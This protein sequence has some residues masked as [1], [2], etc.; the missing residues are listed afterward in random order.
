[1]SQSINHNPF[2]LTVFEH[3]D[4]RCREWLCNLMFWSI[5]KPVPHWSRNERISVHS[6]EFYSLRYAALF[7]TMTL[8]T[9]HLQARNK[10]PNRSSPCWNGVCNNRVVN[11]IRP[12]FHQEHRLVRSEQKLKIYEMIFLLT[13]GGLMV[14]TEEEQTAT[15]LL[16]NE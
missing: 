5:Y 1:M 8:V 10:E 4:N 9:S 2:N 13:G 15:N 7:L 11:S 14:T 6:T 16:R 12:T 3:A